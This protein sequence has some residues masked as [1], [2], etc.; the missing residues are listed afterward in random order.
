MK[1]NSR[2]ILALLIA[3]LAAPLVAYVAL[4]MHSRMP[5]SA[6]SDLIGGFLSVLVTG[7][8]V[9]Y[10]FTIILGL[11]LY[12]LFNRTKLLNHCSLSVGGILIACLPL[13]IMHLDS[14]IETFRDNL[15]TYLI[16]A[17]C[18]LAVANV[19]YLINNHR[20][21]TTSSTADRD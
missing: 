18:G 15:T 17:A 3:P 2:F 9:S 7:S 20:T 6:Q 16:L 1:R 14:G 13:A 10:V 5:I 4:L 8:I 12:W 19:F 11:P 21:P